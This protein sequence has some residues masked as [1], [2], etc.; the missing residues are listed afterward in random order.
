MKRMLFTVKAEYQAPVTELLPYTIKA[1]LTTD[2]D[3]DPEGYDF[4]ANQSQAFEEE[5][6][7]NGWGCWE[8]VCED[9]RHE[10]LAF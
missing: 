7:G 9:K 10:S 2:S 8:D 4:G 6:D 5:E 1:M 3:G